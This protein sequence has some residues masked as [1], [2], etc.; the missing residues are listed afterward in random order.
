[1]DPGE[2]IQEG[3]AREVWEETGVKAKF[4]SIIGFKEQLAYRFG[5]P[6]LYFVCLLKVDKT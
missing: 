4:D 1:M 2:S 3:V 5:Q 6:D